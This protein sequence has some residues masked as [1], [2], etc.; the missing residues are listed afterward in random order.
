MEEADHLASL[1]DGYRYR[2][3]PDAAGS[4]HGVRAIA[5][6]SERTKYGC[7]GYPERT[8]WL[9]GLPWHRQLAGAGALARVLHLEVQ[10]QGCL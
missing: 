7:W 8:K 3:L 6:V 10:A 2:L 5:A 9:Q 4:W 1:R